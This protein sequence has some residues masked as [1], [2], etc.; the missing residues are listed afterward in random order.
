MKKLFTIAI[1]AIL[2]LASSAFADET[3]YP[4]WEWFNGQWVYTGTNPLPPPPPPP[5]PI[6]L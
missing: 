4:D 1:I 5:P 6:K 3:T 2:L